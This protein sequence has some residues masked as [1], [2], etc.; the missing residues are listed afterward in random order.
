MK[1]MVKNIFVYA[2]ICSIISLNVFA[3]SMDGTNENAESNA[4]GYITASYSASKTGTTYY[5]QNKTVRLTNDS[6]QALQGDFGGAIT[7]ENRCSATGSSV[8]AAISSAVGY[9]VDAQK[10]IQYRIHNI[11]VPAGKSFEVTCSVAYFSTDLKVTTTTKAWYGNNLNPEIS[12]SYQNEW[13]DTPTTIE[14]ISYR[15]L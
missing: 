1:N 11:Y 4:R 14:S 8:K 9:N 5:W 13:A 3:G 2:F 6:S 12:Y 7:L 10:T 15:V